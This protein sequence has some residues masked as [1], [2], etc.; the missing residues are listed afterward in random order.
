MR[1]PSIRGIGLR[2]VL[3]LTLPVTGVILVLSTVAQLIGISF[4]ERRTAI[5]A[6][7]TTAAGSMAPL[8]GEHPEYKSASPK[9]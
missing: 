4:S 6:P 5:A 9:R 3:A 2:Y 1:H 8:S 7:A